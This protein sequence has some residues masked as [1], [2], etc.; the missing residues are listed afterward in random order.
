MAKQKMWKVSDML[1]YAEQKYHLSTG[2]DEFTGN[3]KGETYKR[4]IRR[5][6]VSNNLV[7]KDSNTEDYRYKLPVAIAKSFI[8]TTMNEYFEKEY[9]KDKEK[10]RKAFAEKDEALNRKNL[11]ALSEI[12]NNPYQEEYDDKPTY[13]EIKE[14]IH[15]FMLEAIFHIFYDFN[16]E[17]YIED[18]YK[19]DSL[20]DR[21]DPA[22]P[23]MDG[24]SELDEKL[25]N[26]IKNY[27][28]PKK[29]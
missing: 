7:A 5:Q 11:E 29:K 8:D 6:L 10:V 25:K 21:D 2:Y 26:P 28:T 3:S 22:N 23:F 4:E 18:Y 1:K 19:R 14:E 16:E 15:K 27:C 9:R 20:V 12:A 17:Q 24:Y 13:G